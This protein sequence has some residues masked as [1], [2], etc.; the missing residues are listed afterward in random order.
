MVRSGVVRAGA[1][2]RAGGGSAATPRSDTIVHRPHLSSGAAQELKGR[3]VSLHVVVE[4]QIHDFQAVYGAR[5]QEGLVLLEVLCIHVG[6]KVLDQEGYDG[7]RAAADG[8][9]QRVVALGVPRRD[10][11][12]LGSFDE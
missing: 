9:E 8:Q 3:G 7:E 12:G 11:G 5:R 4:E 2:P 6:A 10:L 1:P